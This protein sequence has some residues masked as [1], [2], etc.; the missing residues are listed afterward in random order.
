MKSMKPLK[1]EAIYDSYMLLCN[2]SFEEWV[3]TNRQQLLASLAN[4]V[5]NRYF[6]GK[7]DIEPP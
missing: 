6:E 7:F 3:E 2:M 1:G 4:L 5:K